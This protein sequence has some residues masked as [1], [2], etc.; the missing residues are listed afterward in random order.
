MNYLILVITVLLSF[1]AYNRTDIFEKL[2]FRPF[3]I[4]H[5]KEIWRWVSG[6]FIHANISHLLVN[7]LTFYFFSGYAQGFYQ[8]LFGFWG[9]QLAFLLMYLAAI[10]MSS[11][12]DFYKHKDNFNY[13]AL[14]ASGAVSAVVFTYVILN[15]MGGI[16]LYFFIDMPAWIFG[17]LYL[18]YEQY[19]ARKVDD[20]IGHYAHFFGAVF[21]IVTVF[22]VYPQSI[23]N[24]IAYFS[25]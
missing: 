20:H 19:M 18:V 16:S 4:H 10:V 7:M 6:G 14:G 23:Q 2:L 22:I 1:Y 5:N 17:I 15:P 9:G 21:G 12:Y 24:I 13:S 25:F 8:Q 3:N 11:M